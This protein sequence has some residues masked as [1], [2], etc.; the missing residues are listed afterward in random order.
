MLVSSVEGDMLGPIQTVI[1]KLHV[2]VKFPLC[3]K[4]CDV[5]YQLPA[6]F[7]SGNPCTQCDRPLSHD[8]FY[9]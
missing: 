9:D 3:A 2:M 5:L 4:Q 7:I 8:L 1:I 6:L